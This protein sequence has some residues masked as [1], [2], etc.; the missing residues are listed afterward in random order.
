MNKACHYSLIVTQFCDRHI[1]TQVKDNEIVYVFF[2]NLVHT[3]SWAIY[4]YF[5]LIKSVILLHLHFSTQATVYSS[6]VGN[7]IKFKL[8]HI[9][10]L[11]IKFV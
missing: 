1:I 4:A 10:V 7:K 3:K 5:C 9:Y 11:K 8:Q 6:S 2:L